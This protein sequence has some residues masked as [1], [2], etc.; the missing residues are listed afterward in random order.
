MK[1][2]ADFRQNLSVF[3]VLCLEK[4]IRFKDDFIS[5]YNINDVRD[6]T[7]SRHSAVY[8]YFNRVFKRGKFV[9]GF[10]E[11]ENI[12]KSGN[13]VITRLSVVSFPTT[14]QSLDRV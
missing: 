1:G 8:I 3:S 5:L 4:I 9:S 2:W 12:Q 11:F 14:Y 7:H 10:T 13:P 6:V